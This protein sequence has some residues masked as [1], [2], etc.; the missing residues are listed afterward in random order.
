[1]TL[2]PAYLTDYPNMNSDFPFHL[3]IHTL[4][5]GFPTH[6]H[7]FMEFSFV[8]EGEGT[9]IINGVSHPMKPGTFTCVLPY[10][11][12]EIHTRPGSTLRLYNCIFGLNIGLGAFSGL[13]VVER[14]LDP[15]DG[16]TPFTQFQE[17]DRIYMKALL[18]RL[19]E[20]YKGKDSWRTALLGAGLIEAL[21]RFDRHRR[22]I[23]TA[24]EKPPQSVRARQVWQVIYYV[25]KH[26]ADDLKLGELAEKFHFSASHLSE[27]FTRYVGHSFVH[28]LH[29]IRI[30]HAVGL[31]R[32]TQMSIADVAFEVGYGS[33]QTFSRVFKAYK[34]VTPAAYR[35]RKEQS[36]VELNR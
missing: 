29:E 2:Y 21:A 33:Y 27:L 20:E 8:L 7:D 24:V 25:H 13:G 14:F 18:D 3:A 9:E 36:D 28:V 5:H 16:T 23:E 15:M 31:L 6:R 11:V 19:F 34:K 12:H 30:R 26:Y 1:M 35:N 17:H 10:E 32:S 22:T 4:P